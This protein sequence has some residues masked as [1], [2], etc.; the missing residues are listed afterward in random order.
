MT[1]ETTRKQSGWTMTA[2][3][4]R[5]SSRDINAAALYAV[6][7]ILGVVGAV[8]MS[9]IVLAA[10]AGISGIAAFAT[11]RGYPIDTDW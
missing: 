7:A 8:L 5:P 6:L 4:I 10:V 11:L 2:M 3:R 9:S 1:G